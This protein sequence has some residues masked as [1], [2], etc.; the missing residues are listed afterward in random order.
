M[1]CNANR[2]NTRTTAAM[3]DAEGLVQVHVANIAANVAQD[4]KSGS[5]VVSN[6]RA[7]AFSLNYALARLGLVEKNA[8]P[9]YA[10]TPQVFT[11]FSARAWSP[12]DLRG[13]PSVLYV[14][15]INIGSESA[16]T[17]VASWLDANCDRKALLRLVPDTGYELK[18]RF[19]PRA[20]QQPY[21]IQLHR[22]DC[23]RHAKAN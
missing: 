19:F 7:F 4:V 15:G 8:V 16:D 3:R 1:L 5:T 13:R 22:Y 14:R 18:A 10:D 9:G 6:S 11:H 2:T 20:G 17:S 23:N 21:R 12:D